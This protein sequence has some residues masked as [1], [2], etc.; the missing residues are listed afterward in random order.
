MRI[1]RSMIQRRN[2]GE[3]TD[4]GRWALYFYHD[5]NSDPGYF[6]DCGR[7]RHHINRGCE[8]DAVR[9]NNHDRDVMLYII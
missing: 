5:I 7:T 3:K 4:S 2:G 9:D 1:L 6:F 8:S